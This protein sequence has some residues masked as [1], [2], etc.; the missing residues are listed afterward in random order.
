MLLSFTEEKRIHN[1][2]D[3]LY[4]NKQDHTSTFHKT[5]EEGRMSILSRLNAKTSLLEEIRNEIDPYLSSIKKNDD[6]I[7]FLDI[8]QLFCPNHL[9]DDT[10]LAATGHESLSRYKEFC[11]AKYKIENEVLEISKKIFHQN[12]FEDWRNSYFKEYLKSK[13]QEE[14][15]QKKHQR[16]YSYYLEKVERSLFKQFFSINRWEFIQ[17]YLTIGAP[18]KENDIRSPY[19]HQLIEESINNNDSTYQKLKAHLKKLPDDQII[20]YLKTMRS[21]DELNRDLYGKYYFLF[22]SGRNATEKDLARSFYPG[23]GFGFSKS[24]AFTEN[25]PL[26]S[27]FKIFTGYEALMNCYHHNNKV[28]FPI[29]P[30]TIIDQ[31][32]SYST[33][34]TSNTVL[35][36]HNNYTPIK[37][38]YKGGRLPRGHLNIGKIDFFG[39]MEKS[40]NLYFSLLAANIIEKPENFLKTTQSLGFGNKTNIDLPYEASG[41]LPNDILNNKTSLYSFAFG[42]HSLIVTPLQTAIALSALSTNGEVLKPQIIKAIA[43]IEPETDLNSILYTKNLTYKNEYKNIGIFFP[44]FPEGEKNYQHTLFSDS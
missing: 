17:A 7:L 43:N 21:Y 26:G 12:D 18:I 22:K 27:S 40:S 35:G 20:P 1:L 16:P 5:T 13:R 14:K 11:N 32:P 33:K 15:I 8:L 6:K 34:I 29:N 39:A 28:S 36:Y 31:S 19:F 4:S 10:L 2:I 3:A 38:I 9:F 41:Y 24:F 30:M 37:R 23:K 42:Q 25:M 44:L